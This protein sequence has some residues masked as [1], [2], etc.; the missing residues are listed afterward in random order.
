M[1]LTH[2]AVSHHLARQVVNTPSLVICCSLG[3]MALLVASGIRNAT[4][5]SSTRS[6]QPFSIAGRPYHQVR[7][8][9]HSASVSTG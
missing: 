7:Q 3:R 9:C 5:G 1:R 8:P 2:S 4:S 6:S